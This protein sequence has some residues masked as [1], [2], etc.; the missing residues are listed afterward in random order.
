M[1]E[2]EKIIEN[3]EEDTED[4]A[5]D[6]E[7]YLEHLQRLQAEF[8]NFQK[9]VQKEKETLLQFA[10]KELLLQL[11]EVHDNF[12][13]ALKSEG[14]IEEGVE[15][16][17]KQSNDLLKK[18]GVTEVSNEGEFDP[19][20]HEAVSKEGDDNKITGV[21]Q[22]GYTFKDKLLRPSK[23]KLGGKNNE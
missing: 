6:A 3:L 10:N 2:E 14:N 20:L 4:L 21:F 15:M 16:I 18:E 5:E 23:V 17:F 9:R 7:D 19:N 22:K 13:R 11:L 12:E 8:N 1:N